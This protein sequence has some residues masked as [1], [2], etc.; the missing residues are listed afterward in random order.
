[1]GAL[2]GPEIRRQMGLGKIQIRPFHPDQLGPNSYNLTLGRVLL[3]YARPSWPVRAWKMLRGDPWCLDMKEDNPTRMIS[4]PAEG[5]ILWPGHLYLG[6]TREYTETHSF[7]PVIEG[8]S[9]VGRLGMFVHVTA[10]YGDHGFCA[11]W[12]LELTTVYPTRVYADVEICQIAYDVLVGDEAPYDSAKYQG[13]GS[14]PRASRLWM[15]FQKTKMR[16]GYGT[17]PAGAQAPT[18]DR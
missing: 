15:D 8:R 10:G 5:R 16:D 1:M 11:H 17:T 7:V 14:T 13:Q 12:T 9:S 4:I 2:S 18:R 6:A 3:V